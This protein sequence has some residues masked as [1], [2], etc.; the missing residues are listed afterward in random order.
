MAEPL[1]IGAAEFDWLERT[2]RL[3]DFLSLRAIDDLRAQLPSLELRSYAAGEEIVREGESGTDV[4]L[5]LEGSLS[6]SRKRAWFGSKTVGR[7]ESGA[8]FGEVGFLVQ[9]PRS[10]TVTASAASKI[11]RLGAADMQ[12]LLSQ[13]PRFAQQLAALAKERQ[14]KLKQ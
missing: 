7:L 6:V 4:F 11:F 1:E 13:N 14:Q 8:L 12:R 2:L 3:S 5:L 10:A 9:S